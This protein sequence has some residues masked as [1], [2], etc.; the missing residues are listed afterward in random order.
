MH[1]QTT[2]SE[3]RKKQ[4][5]E[6]PLNFKTTSQLN[7]HL[8]TH[9]GVKN[10]QCPE[11]G[12]SFAQRYNMM[13]HYR[14]H[15]GI[16]RK[17]GNKNHQCSICDDSF[18]SISNLRIHVKEMHSLETVSTVYIVDAYSEHSQSY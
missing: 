7:Q 8:V 14:L 9:T 10:H 17:K 5:P 1:F 15:I 16:G 3:V 2:H 18:S 12:K 13:A 6:C 11:C 4:C